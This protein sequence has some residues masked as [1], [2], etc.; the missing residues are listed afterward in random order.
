MPA[1]HIRD[2]PGLLHLRRGTILDAALDGGVPVPFQ[3]RSGQCGSCKCRLLR[4]LIEHD[5]HLP[6]ALSESERTDGWVLAC[7]ARPKTD[8]EVDYAGKLDLES[9][10]PRRRS[11]RV[12]VRERLT[13]D[14]HRLELALDGPPLPFR[15]GQFARLRFGRLPARSYSMA[16]LPAAERLEFLV[17]EVREGRVSGHIARQLSAGDR[18]RVEGPFGHAFLRTASP[19]TIV[20]A[21]GGSGLAPILAIARE[22]TRRRIPCP[23]ALYFGV[24]R[25][26]DLFALS[27]LTRLGAQNPH[28]SIHLV[29]SEPPA[30]GYGH[31]SGLPHEA[32][33]A[34]FTDLELAQIYCAGPPPMVEAVAKT[35][36]GLGAAAGNIHSDPFIHEGAAASSQA[37]RAL[38]RCLDLLGRS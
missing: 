36:Q 11:A 15:A 31:R 20:A 19:K 5:D 12:A 16:N 13:A 10:A 7:R 21:A 2:W 14:I 29:L 23:L 32:I 1:V 34:D 9:P 26:A 33:A 25:E 18:V 24:R 28:L 22:A 6:E 17:R 30:A 3:C 27:D 35:A 8:V 4:G 37:G 38:K